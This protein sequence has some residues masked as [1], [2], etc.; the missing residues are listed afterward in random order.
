MLSAGN[1]ELVQTFHLLLCCFTH[2][3]KSTPSFLLK[4]PYGMFTV[5]LFNIFIGFIS[6]LR[7]IKSMTL[8]VRHIGDTANPN[9]LKNKQN[10]TSWGQYVFPSQISHDL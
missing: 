2:V 6:M 3:L 9:A 4:P 1:V 8:K 10:L 7:A 5:I